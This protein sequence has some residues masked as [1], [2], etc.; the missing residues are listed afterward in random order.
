MDL[1]QLESLEA[2]I[3]SG[4]FTAAAHRLHLTQPALWARVKG[5][6]D[7]FGVRLFERRGR[8]V[9]PTAACL[10]L[11]PRIRALLDDARS[12][13]SIAAD[14]REGR[15]LPA[16]IGC[17]QYHV[18]H[19]LA[20]CIA[21]LLRQHPGS[22]FPQ[23]VPVSHATA[24][25]TLAR[26]DV[27][28]L[29]SLR[30]TDAA[31]DGFRLYPVFIAVVGRGIPPGPFDLRDLEGRNV[32]TFPRDSAVRSAIEQAC[33][34]AGVHLAVVYEDRDARSLLALAAEGVATAVVVSEALS[35]RELSRAGR[36]AAGKRVLSNELWLQWRSEESLSPSARALRDIMRAESR[37]ARI[38]RA[39][40]QRATRRDHARVGRR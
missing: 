11:R 25:P 1:P 24:A 10:Q 23:V 21:K 17:A 3:D 39:D 6:E 5:L 14:I 32:A 36:A 40:V 12:L 16:K 22:P 13:S 27:D 8:G 35:A 15:G 30:V 9:V 20:G 28:L 19:F 34:A 31:W 33:A 7:D 38:A 26:G 2:V 18:P 29:V 37:I 4:S